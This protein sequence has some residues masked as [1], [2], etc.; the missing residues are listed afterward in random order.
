MDERGFLKEEHRMQD[1]TVIYAPSL[2]AV[3]TI[4]A[5]FFSPQHLKYSGCRSKASFLKSFSAKS[6]LQLNLLLLQGNTE[7]WIK[8]TWLMRFP[9]PPPP[10][11]WH[12]NLIL[13]S[14]S[15]LW[16]EFNSVCLQLIWSEHPNCG[17][18]MPEM[19]ASLCALGAWGVSSGDGACFSVPF[20][21]LTKSWQSSSRL[22]RFILAHS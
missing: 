11:S 13:N 5:S 9:P 19:I 16:K 15:P 7:V 12:F 3:P 20:V 14:K 2:H 21:A 18:W 1:F 4:S 17:S 10:Q 22:I 6:C 8:V